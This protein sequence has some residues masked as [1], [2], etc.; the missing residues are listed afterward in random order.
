ME[1]IWKKG[2]IIQQKML[3]HVKLNVKIKLVVSIGHGI[4]IMTLGHV[5]RNM[6][7]ER[8]GIPDL[9]F[10]VP[11]NVHHKSA[12][13]WHMTI[14]KFFIFKMIRLLWIFTGNTQ[15]FKKVFWQT[16]FENICFE[17]KYDH[18]ITLMKNI[19]GDINGFKKYSA[20]QKC[21]DQWNKS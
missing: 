21:H 9:W 17:E 1:M 13:Y 2:N 12:A 19:H 4:Q 15:C 20:Y 5:G 10:L 18:Q 7:K 16:W 11:N 3:K 14:T 6:A 8:L